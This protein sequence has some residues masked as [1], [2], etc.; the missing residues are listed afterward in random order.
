MISPASR[1]LKGLQKISKGENVLL[2]FV[3]GSSEI[4]RFDDLSCGYDYSKDQKEIGAIIS[5]LISEGYLSRGFNEAN[6]S[7]T[8]KGL[9]PYRFSLESFR[10]F[11]FQS[12][13]VPIVASVLTTIITIQITK[14]L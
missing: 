2:T 1:V 10:N 5:Y 9:H 12:V 8:E 13:L 11:L 4:C 3:S 7:L 6:F 14:L